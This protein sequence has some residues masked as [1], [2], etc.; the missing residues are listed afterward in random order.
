MHNLI[1]NTTEVCVACVRNASDVNSYSCSWLLSRS[2]ECGGIDLVRVADSGGGGSGPGYERMH[3]SCLEA[4]GGGGGGAGGG[5]YERLPPSS[6]CDIRYSEL[7]SRCD[8]HDKD[9]SNEKQVSTAASSGYKL[10]T[11]VSCLGRR[12]SFQINKLTERRFLQSLRRRP[13]LV[14]FCHQVSFQKIT[15]S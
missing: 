9:G 4:G 8:D 15:F 10:K 7:R 1:L 6:P 14:A 2:V 11:T 3:C 12:P 5:R 13:R